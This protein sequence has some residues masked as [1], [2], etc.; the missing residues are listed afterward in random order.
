MP[1]QFVVPQFLDVE[2]KIIGPITGRQ[3][4]ILLIT[5]VLDAAIYRIFL[6]LITMLAIGLPVTL[7][8]LAF[9]FAKVNGQPLHFIVLNVVQTM[10]KPFLRVWDK[11][12][13]DQEIKD[14]MIK[15]V[16]EKVEVLPQKPAIQQSRLSELTMVV[17]T[18]GEYV[19]E[20]ESIISGFHTDQS[21]Q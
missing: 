9:A 5:A 16:E 19:P 10:R 4:V 11:Q 17:N 21:E 12:L 15:P 6:S 13:T 1:D 2:A 18:G 20:D 3:F 7:I 14:R 8:G